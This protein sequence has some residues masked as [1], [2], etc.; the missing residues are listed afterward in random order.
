MRITFLAADVGNPTSGTS[1]FA[2]NIVSGLRKLGHDISL[3]GLSVESRSAAVLR[4]H[5]V[6]VAARRASA[7]PMWRQASYLTPYSRVGRTV[8]ELALREAPADRY[9]VLSDV[10]IDAIDVLGSRPSIYL[11]NGEI[12][13]MLLSPSFFATNA[14]TKWVVSRMMA[15]VVRQNAARARRYSRLLANSE[16]TRDFMS[17]LYGTMFAGV[18]Y[19]PVDTER[20]RPSESPATERYA[21]AVA[22][23]E[24]EQGLRILRELAS[25]MPIHVVGGAAVPGARALGVVSEDQLQEE[26]A[27]AQLLLFPIVSEFFGYAVA[28]SL[29]SGTPVLAFDCG[30]PSEL[31]INGATGWLVRDERS[32]VQEARIRFREDLPATMRRAARDSAARFSIPAMAHELVRHLSEI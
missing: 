19:P 31:V 18:V 22:R 21:L 14:A 1:R 29:A 12:T 28:E 8:A 32:F 4:E 11:S 9:V 23:N 15:S 17:F 24:N 30:G 13:M 26:Y 6:R 25:A 3:V 7:V 2:L 27:R 20:F 10:A 5:G 16:F